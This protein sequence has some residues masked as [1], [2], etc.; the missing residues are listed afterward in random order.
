MDVIGTKVLRVAI[1]SHLYLS[2]SGLKPVCNVNI[3]YGTLSLPKIM[4]LD[5]ILRSVI[6][7][8][9][10]DCENC[11]LLDFPLLFLKVYNSR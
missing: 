11:F 9:D 7:L 10:K 2:K 4:P 6:W 1:H 3:V 5:E 8:Q